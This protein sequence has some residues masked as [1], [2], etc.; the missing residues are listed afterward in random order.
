MPSVARQSV[1]AAL[2]PLNVLRFPGAC[3]PGYRIVGAAM[4]E[5]VPAGTSSASPT[6]IDANPASGPATSRI[7]RWSGLAS[8]Y[9]SP[10]DHPN[11]SAYT[12]STPPSMF[13]NSF[14]EERKTS[15]APSAW[16]VLTSPITTDTR[17]TER[18][19]CSNAAR[20]TL[21]CAS[22]TI[23]RLRSVA[24]A[25]PSRSGGN[26]G[27]T[28][29]GSG[30]PRSTR[31]RF[32]P[33]ICSDVIAA[34]SSGGSCPSRSAFV[35]QLLAIRRTCR[36]ASVVSG[37]R[38][39]TASATASAHTRRPVS[40]VEVGLRGQHRSRTAT[41]FGP[42]VGRGP[43]T[44]VTVFTAADA[45]AAAIVGKRSRR[46]SKMCPFVNQCYSTL[47]SCTGQ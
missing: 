8:W 11:I 40:S 46:C 43:G 12:R 44:V 20:F 27:R 45:A 25:H 2:A 16:T 15:T 23:V 17:G 21:S 33:A 30:Q 37:N 13:P 18:N 31:R 5:T 24:A 35:L 47:Y 6:G 19:T 7:M 4:N 34:S 10:Y 14:A 39:A 26:P 28:A 1:N 29:G 9:G 38:V 42:S 36:S 3:A 22:T 32:P 41:T